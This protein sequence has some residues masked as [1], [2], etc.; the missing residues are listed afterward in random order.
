MFI[1]AFPT[2]DT[3]LKIFWP[4]AI[5]RNVSAKKCNIQF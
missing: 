2:Q 4:W 5:Y 1:L 3:I